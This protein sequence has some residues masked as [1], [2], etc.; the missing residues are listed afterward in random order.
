MCVISREDRNLKRH[1]I[2][3]CLILF[4]DLF[5]TQTISLSLSVCLWA[6]FVVA[7]NFCFYSEENR[8]LSLC[9]KIAI[10]L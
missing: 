7:V 8:K 4:A 2:W 10:N 5:V 1:F 6:I 3:I 9:D